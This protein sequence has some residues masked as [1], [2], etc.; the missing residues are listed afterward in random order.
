M[1]TTE[2]KLPDIGEG[3]AEGEIVKWLVALG[4]VVQ[5]DDPL[6]E[7]MT[8]KATVE[9]TS[10][11]TGTILEFRAAEGDVVD[12]GVVIVVFGDADEQ[13]IEP[14]SSAVIGEQMADEESM[15]APDTVESV[16]EAA[17]LSARAAIAGIDHPDFGAGGNITDSSILATPATRRLSRELGIDL[18][19]VTGSGVGGRVT[20]DDVI[21][22]SEAGEKSTASNVVEL[23]STEVQLPG[24]VDKGPELIMSPKLDQMGAAE[25]EYIPFRGLRQ[26]IAERMVASKNTVPH[27]TY[28]EEA[29]LTHV[30]QLR[31]EA[32][33]AGAERGIKVTYLPFIIRAVVTALKRHPML[34]ARLDEDLSQI[35]LQREYNI[36]IATATDRGLTVP[37]VKNADRFDLLE[38]AAEVERVASAARNGTVALQDLQGSTFTITSIGNIGGV[39]A[40]PIINQPEVAILGI[41]A[42]RKRPVVRDD[43][44]VIRHMV[45]LSMSLDHRVVDG[46]EAALFVRDLVR[47]L[48]DPNLQLLG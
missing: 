27:Y 29:D 20:K 21:A 41:T 19:S 25:G 13:P 40:T 18:A 42:I 9:I 10:P 36:G 28:V 47:Y 7:V 32:K 31:Q 15:E 30:V 6:V 3:T 48:E 17:R 39:M 11:R 1:A 34:N 26:K 45:N 14:P 2:F 4:D 43:E 38:L 23:P 5:E 46:A 16:V 44:I 12:V 24:G 37:V 33:R 8:D 22:A 35:L